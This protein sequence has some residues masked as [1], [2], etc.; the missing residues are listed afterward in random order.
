MYAKTGKESH[1]KY[2]GPVSILPVLKFPHMINFLP[3]S[4]FLRKAGVI[5]H[6]GDSYIWVAPALPLHSCTLT[7]G[8]SVSAH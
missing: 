2:L 8:I 3:K 6:V 7:A 1:S 4:S 5:H